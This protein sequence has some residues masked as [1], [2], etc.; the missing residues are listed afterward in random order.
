M[1][2]TEERP[3]K[4]M[5][6]EA[7]EV[8]VSTISP[9]NAELDGEA[10]HQAAVEVPTEDL[11][12]MSKSQLKKL[13]KQ[14]EWDAGK[15]Y[16]KERQREKNK[17]KQARKAAERAELEA[18][19]AAGEITVE[20]VTEER[21][22]CYARP[23]QTPLSLIMDCDFNHLM[24]E[25]ELISLGAQLTRC[26]SDNKATPFRAHIAISSWGGKL[27]HRFETVLANNQLAWKGVKFFEDDFEAAAKEMDRV[28]RSKDGGK[29]AGV[30]APPGIDPATGNPIKKTEDEP[31]PDT[32]QLETASSIPNLDSTEEGSALPVST[33][34]DQPETTESENILDRLEAS[35]SAQASFTTEPVSTSESAPPNIVYLSSDSEYTL[36]RLSPNT[37]YI[38][39]G[40]VDKNRHKGIC[41]KRA[42]ERG[43]PTAKLPIGEF[44]AMTSRSVLAVNHV[45][46]I[47]LKWMETGDWGEAFLSVM[48]KR[49][50]AKLKSEKGKDKV[51]SGET[52]EVENGGGNENGNGEDHDEMDEDEESEDGNESVRITLTEDDTGEV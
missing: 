2:D 42:C 12:T 18:K 24:T 29:L 11:P 6:L 48:P 8:T 37:S 15:P 50:G 32:A 51:V 47:M 23:I 45:V 52:A 25:K 49:K 17:A 1:S 21:K 27:K 41:Y 22:L 3:A 7:S 14:Q 44:L 39:G 9:A 19:I 34:P 10:K 36:E 28:M 16:R 20:P 35:L 38:I 30:F 13:R 40:I 46:E 4:K 43:I 31:A 26:Y 33:N 5:R